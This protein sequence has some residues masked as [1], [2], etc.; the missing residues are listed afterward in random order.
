[1]LGAYPREATLDR[2]LLVRS[3]E[4]CCDCAESRT[5]CADDCLGEACGKCADECEIHVASATA[6]INQMSYRGG[7][8]CPAFYATSAACCA[9][10][11]AGCCAVR[12]TSAIRGAVAGSARGLVVGGTGLIGLLYQERP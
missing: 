1:M 10:C 11:R 3:I 6:A 12:D 2:G 5:Q 4:A 8:E 7:D 9:I